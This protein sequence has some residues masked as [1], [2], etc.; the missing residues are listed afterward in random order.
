[1]AKTIA[2]VVEK[3]ARR[4]A[5]AGP[6]YEAGIRAGKNQAENAIAAKQLWF[7]ALTQANQRDAFA[8]GLQKSGTAKWQRKSLE[9]GAARWPQGVGAAQPDYQANFG[10]ILDALNAVVPPKRLP[11]GDPGNLLRVAAYNIAA[12]KAAGKV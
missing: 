12:R 4:A 1:M 11:K 7:Q 3:W 2:Q 9:V 6:D 8:K 5:T 10:P